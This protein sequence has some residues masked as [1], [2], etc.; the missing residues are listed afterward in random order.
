MSAGI[1]IYNSKSQVL[2]NSSYKNIALI[3]VINLSDI[4][5]A[6][7]TLGSKPVVIAEELLSVHQK[8]AGV[9]LKYDGTYHIVINN[10]DRA[11]QRL[12]VFGEPDNSNIAGKAGL[13]IYQNGTNEVAFDS[14]LS[15]LNILGDSYHDMLIDPNRRYG[16]IRRVP[17]GINWLMQNKGRRNGRYYYIEQRWYEDYGYDADRFKVFNRYT[18]NY[19]SWFGDRPATN[20]DYRYQVKY[21]PLLVDLTLVS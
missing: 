1:K 9:T 15:Y 4:E 10:S 13:V 16:I 18:H 21:K 14:R 5:K 17:A 3:Q 11:T 6:Q 19:E 2:V 7:I 20:I 12:F 8:M